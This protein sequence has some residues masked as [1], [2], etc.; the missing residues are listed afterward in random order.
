MRPADFQSGEAIQGTVENEMREAESRFE[1]HSDDILE[2][3][4]PL[5][6]T[7]LGDV[8]DVVRMHEDHYVEILSLSPERI[9]LRC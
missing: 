8:R 2:V 5:Q 7:L 1:R 9:V 6:A 3:A 4:A